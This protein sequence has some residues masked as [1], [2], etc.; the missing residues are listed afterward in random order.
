MKTI[1]SVI[2]VLLLFSISFDSFSQGKIDESKKELKEGRKSNDTEDASSSSS[3]DNLSDNI[4]LEIVGKAFLYVTYY[5]FIGNYAEEDHLHSNLTKYPYYNGSSG[6]YENPDSVPSQAKIL[7]LDLEDKLLLSP[8]NIFGNHLKAKFRPFQFFYLQADYFQL[9]EFNKFDRSFSNLSLFNFNF[10]YDRI[11]FE[12]FNLGWTL[13]LNYAGNDV[14]KF[15]V[16]WGLNS[17]IF[18][19]K[20]IS[21]YSSMKWGSIN[22][23]PVNEFEIQC[24]YHK[25][26]YFYSIGYEH[27]KIATPTYDFISIG[28]GI[29][30]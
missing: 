20:T 30:F 13:G 22:Y 9:S 24:R 28:G 29:Y 7:R 12:K 16:S 4:V 18:L 2:L 11:R 5:A 27:L 21:F 25:K 6:N 15:G 8:P 23:V 26:N 14:N 10:C 1:I 17:D 19:L 3:S